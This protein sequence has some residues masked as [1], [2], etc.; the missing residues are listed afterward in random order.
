M[1]IR[2]IFDLALDDVNRA[3]TVFDARLGRMAD[4]ASPLKGSSFDGDSGHSV[5]GISDPTGE[6]GTAEGKTAASKA[7]AD[8]RELERAVR[9]L[10]V[11]AGKIVSLLRDYP[12]ERKA[13]SDRAGIGSCD[14][15]RHYCTGDSN[16]RLRIHGDVRLCDRCRMRRERTDLKR[17]A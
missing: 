5:G 16:D 2:T 4:M 12:D 3:A 17:D 7:L 10:H 6:S 13:T 9:A 11:N 15:C 1:R 14:E 8:R